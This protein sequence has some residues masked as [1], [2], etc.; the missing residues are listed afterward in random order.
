MNNY[1]C[2]NLEFIVNGNG[3]IVEFP[4]LAPPCLDLLHVGLFCTFFLA[5]TGS[6]PA[7]RGPGVRPG[8]TLCDL[9]VTC[10]LPTTRRVPRCNTMAPGAALLYRV[11][12]LVELG[13]WSCQI[14]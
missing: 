14:A 2:E 6:R 1:E 4:S 9:R 5:D 12:A 10:A 13:V 11:G 7:K 8:C 3:D